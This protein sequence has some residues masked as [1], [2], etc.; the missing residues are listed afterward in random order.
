MSGITLTAAVRQNLL[1]LQN[2][3]D[4]MSQTQTRLATGKKVNSALDNPGAF[5]TASGLD[6]RAGDLSALLDDMGQAVQT[7]KA[8]DQGIKAITTLV[9]AAKAKANQAL[10]TADATARAAYATEFDEIMAQIEFVAT[11]SG[12]NGKNLLGADDVTVTYNE[13]GSS[14]STITAVDYTDATGD[15][16]V[17]AAANAWVADADITAALDD[18]NAALTTLRTQAATFGTSLTV[19]QAREDFTKNLVA[20][21]QEGSAKLTLAD[22]NEE[23]AN[24]LALQTRQ[25]LSVTALSMAAQAEQAVLRLF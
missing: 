12:Y 24:L 17:A 2:T 8:A 14:T 13:D 10:G 20:T 25:A 18:V 3:A 16:G 19:V 9:E 11:D 22:I 6:N 15:L 7:L 4:L 23:S 21:L 1:A 5:F